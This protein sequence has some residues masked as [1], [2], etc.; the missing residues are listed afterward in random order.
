MKTAPSL[1]RLIPG[2]VILSLSLF[3]GTRISAQND[4]HWLEL[5]QTPGANFYSVKAAFDSAWHD[6]EQ[7][8]LEERR[9]G[10]S[11][12]ETD[13]NERLDATY[14]KYKRW[15]YFMQPRVGADGD[16]SQPAATYRNYMEYLN[17]NPA[18]MAQFNASVARQQQSN[19]WTFVGPT[20]APTGSGAGRLCCIRFDPQSTDIIYVGAPAGGLWKST[21][22]GASWT[23]L[24]DF[25]PSI[26]CSDV[27][28]DPNN[29]NTIYIGTGDIDAGDSPSIG[30]MKSTDGGITWN[31]TGLSFTTSQVRRIAKILIDPTNSNILY[32]GT[33]AGIYK[34][35]DA[36]ANWYQLSQLNVM[37]MEFKPGDPNTIY[38]GKVSFYKTTN[39]GLTWTLVS[40]GLPQ[41]S[42]ISRIAIA[43]TPDAPDNVYIVAAH[44]GS[45]AFEGCYVSTNSGNSFNPQ[46]GTPNILGWD[47]NGGD[48]EGQGWYDLAI[49]V[50]PY[51]KD[52][53]IIGGVNVWRSDDMGQTWS[54]NA[55]WYGGGGAPYVHADV[56]DI[57]FEPGS[58]GNYY[59]GCDGG[60]F[61]TTNDG[62]NFT[63][64]SNNLCIAQIYRL[65]LAQTNAG[66]LITGH[67]DNG[68]NVKSGS[69]YFEGLGGDGMDCFIDRTNANVMFGELY[70]GDFHRSTNGGTSWSTITNGLTGTGGWVTPWVQDPVNPNLLYAGYDQLFKSTNQGSNWS[71][72]STT[73]TGM[74]TDIAVA[75][76]NNQYIYVT[77]GVGLLRSTDAGVT[78]ANILP[79][80]MAG[81]TISRIAVSSY[82]EN[83]VWVSI[84]GYTANKKAFYSS[85]GGVTW[86]NISYG[87]PNIPANCIVAVPGSGSDAVFIGCDAGV[88]YRD[89]SSATWQPYFTGLPNAPVF[90]LEV[91]AATMKLR[92]ATYGRGVWEC[93]IDQSVLLPAASFTSDYTTVCPGQTVQFTDLSAPSL[94]SWSW[95]FPGGTPS[96]S[97]QQNPAV[98]YNTPGVYPVTLTATNSNGSSSVT[99]SAYI[100][101][102][103]SVAPPY[104]EGFTAVNFVP[105]GWSAVNNGNQ[106]AMWKRNAGVGHNGMGC[107][108]YDNYNNSL[109][110]EQDDIRSMPLNFTGYTSL[111]L[112]FDVAYARY[113]SSR[114]DSLEVLV[115]TDCGTSWTRIYVKGGSTLATAS[116]STSPFTPTSS[117]WRTETV[118]INSYAGMPNVLFAF[119]NRNRHGNFLY[120]DDINI[121]GTVNAAP[122]AAMNSTTACANGIVSFSD[123]SVPA[124]SSWTWYF[125][126]SNT[127]TSTQQN[128]VVT[129]PAAG[130]YTVSL[131]ATN[132]F[133]SDSTSMVVTVNPAITAD[134]G[135]DTSYCSNTYV[136]LQASGG[137][138]YS[139]SPATNLTNPNNASTGV[140]MTASQTFT[141][142]VTDAAGCSAVDSVSVTIRPLPSFG[143]QA[144]QTNICLGDTVLLNTTNNNYPFS[145]S[146]ASS[147]SI[148]TG[149]SAYAWPGSTTTYSITATDSTG[150]SATGTKTIV[151]YPPL[152]PAT[153]LVNGF[154]LT[155]SVFG[156]SYQWYLNGNP[157]AG[158]TS[159][160]Y[161]ATQVG[162]YSVEAL[163][164]QGCSS[165]MSPVVLV[166]GMEEAGGLL[167]SIAPNPNNGSF[168]LAFVTPYESDYTLH[169]YSLDGRLAYSEELPKFSGP[170]Q[171]RIDLSAFGAGTYAIR[172][173][174]GK[175][176]TVKLVIVE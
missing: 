175:K 21:N 53:V 172:L 104:V 58:F 120:L 59:I 142:T 28:I 71:P 20:G 6:R 47:P 14:F 5:W 99:Q 46:S 54:L 97:V 176:Q 57:V 123:N 55:H 145:W 155:C 87:L 128:P 102:S 114:S 121:T 119:R 45:Y 32:A 88:Y 78:W 51:D 48:S 152:L 3:T 18:A 174:D 164:Y 60:I 170:Y 7:E 126:G 81:S 37:D 168:E 139:W 147:L 115:S 91:Y 8:M 89:N 167:F 169:V 82:D 130:T 44:T 95:T 144:S 105:A 160:T 12:S 148:A 166:D 76:S 135:Q 73:M 64:L 56:H 92:A 34:S 138:F 66:T 132:S 154:N 69:N 143:L 50:A 106:T 107:A 161:T 101:V 67:Q 86:T 100:T 36:G 65:G 162:N 22:S 153:V 90:D 117:Q 131:V 27:A 111:S 133:G 79:G 146:P 163:T 84:S 2:L 72:T 136:L 122:N 173:S 63:D 77:T 29:S 96:T 110:G 15:E 25:L 26:G 127:P 10:G 33:S 4:E 94:T 116:T 103:G 137:N 165:G 11:R 93:D 98:V 157:I 113:S 13:E 70:Y 134:A 19:S 41:S 1:S 68:T 85:D 35:Y 17:S 39:G 9:N 43:V 149:D 31:T 52:I 151:V 141:V 42:Q 129:W 112:N 150:C 140:Q 109:G 125:P 23:C 80:S 118:N 38:A 108:Y 74:L 83:K 171:K 61:N 75:P 62:G 156:Y 16:M 158:A 24:T 40:S 30:V 159:Q 49:A 124:A